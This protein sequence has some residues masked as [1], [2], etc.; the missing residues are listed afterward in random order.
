MKK[1]AFSFMAFIALLCVSS[2]FADTRSNKADI[3]KN[4]NIFTAI[5]KELQTSYVDTIDA[6]KTMRLAINTMLYSID[7]YTEY[8]PKEEQDEFMTISTGEFGGIGAYIV[9]D[10]NGDVTV[11]LP[12]DNTP[13]IKTGLRAGDKFITIDGDTVLGIGSDKVRN[14]LRGPAGTTVKVTVRRPYVKDSILN[15][16]IK[17]EKIIVDPVPYYDVVADGVGYIGLTTFNE[18]SYGKV[19][20]AFEKLKA[21]NGIKSLILDL[22]DNGGGLMESAIQIVGLF[23]DKGTEVLVTRGKG[24]MNN[25]VYKTTV[26]PVDTKMPLVVLIDEGS[27]SSSE[28][29]TGA[30]QDLDRAVIVGNRSY[31]KGLVQSTRQIPYDGLLKVTIAKYYIPSGRLIQAIDYSRRREDGSVQRTP[32]SLTNVFYTKNHRPVKDGG[33]ITPDVTVDRPVIPKL[34]EKLVR[35]NWVYDY[36]VYFAAHHDSISSTQR[37][38]LTDSI[39][40]DFKRFVDY[41]KL[42]YDKVCE[43]MISRLE[44]A[45]KNEGYYNDEVKANIDSL[46]ILLHHDIDKDMDRNR[47]AVRFYL[48][49]EIVTRMKGTR[50]AIIHSVKD[51]IAID[52]AVR[53]LDNTVRYTSILN[54]KK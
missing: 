16:E 42:N 32:D 30:L 49:S 17:R 37:F 7:P 25:K 28:I 47:S 15:F 46:K 40:D 20:E 41:D 35:G 24:D 8:I 2:A 6:N 53:V 31:G 10:E 3:S 22:R 51:D 34:T 50:G 14:K 19:R 9:G 54:P 1:F 38:V 5:Y 39:Y 45:A 36:S 11:S 43:T 18:K 44:E 4:L 27:A 13:A 52:S 26:K 33:G 23:V 21:E 12:Q 29:V 48:E